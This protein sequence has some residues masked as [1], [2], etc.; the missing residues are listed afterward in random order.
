M[1]KRTIKI[2]NNIFA[3]DAAP[4]AMPK[5]PNAPATNAMIRKIKVQRNIGFRF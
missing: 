4:A 3:I 1:R 5:K 2:K